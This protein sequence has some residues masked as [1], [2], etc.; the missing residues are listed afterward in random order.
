MA[1]GKACNDTEGRL[2]AAIYAIKKVKDICGTKAAINVYHA[3]FHSIMTYGVMFWGRAADS[4]RVFI[5]QKRAVRTILGM[6]PRDSCRE[7]FK[8]LGIL[9]LAGVY[10]W[11]CLLFARKNLS[12]TPEN[13][14]FH[15]H[16]TRN[17]HDIRTV[18]HR[19]TKV[20]NSFV[21]LSTR[22]FNKLPMN[23]R[24]M[25]NDIYERRVKTYL[26]D[27]SYYTVDV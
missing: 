27:K 18:K 2:S 11:E 9:T 7:V 24:L 26:V 14:D 1:M 13:A 23:V 8:R 10:I 12:N 22:L 19:L 4:S 16:N 20:S 17:K 25:V 3:Y 15:D 6:H 21:C 5:L